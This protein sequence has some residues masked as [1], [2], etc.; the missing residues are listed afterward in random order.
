MLGFASSAPTYVSPTYRV[1]ITAVL[2]HLCLECLDTRQQSV[3]LF[4]QRDDPPCPCRL[5]TAWRGRDGA[6]SVPSRYD[7]RS[8]SRLQLVFLQSLRLN[9]VTSGFNKLSLATN[10]TDAL[11]QYL[12]LR[13]GTDGEMTGEQ[14]LGRCD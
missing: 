6:V 5:R 4:K 8:L 12:N 7:E 14:L 3:D 2:A 11:A 1:G 9:R 13:V 10:W